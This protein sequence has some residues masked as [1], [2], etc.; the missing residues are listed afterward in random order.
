MWIIQ[1]HTTQV[2][3]KSQEEKPVPGR[4]EVDFY[5]THLYNERSPMTD[6]GAALLEWRGPSR[7]YKKR[8]RSFYQTTAAIVFLVVVILFFLRG[9]LIIAV[10]LSLVFVGYALAATK[11]PS[12]TYKIT[13]KGVWVDGVFYSYSHLSGF[14]FEK[15]LENQ[16]LVLYAP[17]RRS[18][19]ILLVIPQDKKKEARREL[20]EHLVYHEKPLRSMVEAVGGWLS[21]AIPLEDKEMQAS[22]KNPKQ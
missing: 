15:Q 7:P 16:V 6:Q 4:R 18:R 11:P 20:Q 14:W 22:Q 19:H 5:Q 9:W 3:H 13:R 1:A 12:I 10:V 8:D 2:I 17:N 21:R